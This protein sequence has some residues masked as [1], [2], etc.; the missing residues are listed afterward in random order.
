VQWDSFDRQHTHVLSAFLDEFQSSSRKTS[1][2]IQAQSPPDNPEYEHQTDEETTPS[3]T[4][5][6]KTICIPN[7]IVTLPNI[8][9]FSPA[10]IH[11]GLH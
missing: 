5:G 9:E 2:V 7:F 10:Q 3:L 11:R 4:M 8:T 1:C 6:V